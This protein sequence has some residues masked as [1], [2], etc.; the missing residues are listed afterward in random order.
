MNSLEKKSFY[1]FLSLYFISTS[2]FITISAYWYYESQKN[3]IENI[4]Y[5]KM[6]HSADTL[7]SKII[8][9]HMSGG[10]FEFKDSDTYQISLVD[11][12]KELLYGNKIPNV[13]FVSGFYKKDDY[14]TL[15]STSTNLHLGVAYIVIRNNEVNKELGYLKNSVLFQLFISLL[16]A[17]II[18]YILSKIFTRPLRQRIL[19][20]ENFIRDITHELN[21]PITALR[22]SSSQAL[23]NEKYLKNTLSNISISTKQLYDIYN[24]LTYLNFEQ[25]FNDETIDLSDE[26]RK[27]IEYYQ[28]LADSKK[29]K[30]N[31]ELENFEYII[32]KNKLT[33]LISN[34]INNAIKYSHPNSSIG[35]KLK[36]GAFTVSDNGI[37]IDESKLNAIFQ[38]YNRQSD[39]SGGFGIGLNVVKTICDE[40]K[41][42][43]IVESKIDVGTIFTL[44]FKVI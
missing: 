13:Q 35:I 14:Y 20:I 33:L 22:L 28:Q 15:V 7:S 40:Y 24:S 1:S 10:K 21:T 44:D 16:I 18:G 8:H 27:I 31:I 2:L 42:R 17:S 12:N 34:L 11:K 29:I 43:I 19:Q 32:D 37:G 26:I 6:Q 39:Y 23:K 36:D 38:K 3:S 41:I 25:S 30:F 9:A 4:T 5:Y